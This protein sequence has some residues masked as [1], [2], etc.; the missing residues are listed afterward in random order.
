TCLIGLVIAPILGSHMVEGQANVFTQEIE[1][2]VVQNENEAT[3]LYKNM[4]IQK[5]VDA[6]TGIVTA[7]V[8]YQSS[9]NGAT[10]TKS[11]KYV[12][13]EAQVEAKIKALNQEVINFQ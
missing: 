3:S 11:H 7:N 1:Q 4:D 5:S 9:A 2:E 12:G 10:I 6:E 13:T 8:T